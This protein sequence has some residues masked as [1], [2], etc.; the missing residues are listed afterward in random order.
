MQLSTHP[1]QIVTLKMEALYSS[2]TWEETPQKER[3]FDLNTVSL[4]GRA[5][6]RNTCQTLQS[7]QINNCTYRPT[8]VSPLGWGVERVKAV[9]W[10]RRLVA[11]PGS[12]PGQP[13]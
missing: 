9:L 1:S 13:M 6:S 3:N 10:A 8:Q 12:I 2:E 5:K 11:G 4:T 7:K